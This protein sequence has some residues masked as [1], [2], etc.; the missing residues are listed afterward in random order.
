VNTNASVQILLSV[1]QQ[2]N[3]GQGQLIFEVSR[4]HTNRHNYTHTH[5]VGVGAE[6]ATYTAHNKHE[7]EIYIPSVAFEPAIPAI[8]RP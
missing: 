6:A 8:K 3:L 4:S 5:A 7:D 2:P 1:E